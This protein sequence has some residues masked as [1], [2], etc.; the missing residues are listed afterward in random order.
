MQWLLG[1][2]THGKGE[3]GDNS[4]KMSEVMHSQALGKKKE[5]PGKED[6]YQQRHARGMP[7]NNSARFVEASDGYQGKL[8]TSEGS[9]R[10]IG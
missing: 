8:G 2:V 5:S 7:K 6:T 1:I 9:N 4:C 3:D 10:F